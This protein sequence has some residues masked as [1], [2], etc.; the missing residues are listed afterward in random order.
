MENSGMDSR[1]MW[2]DLGEVYSYDL[3]LYDKALNAY[4]QA[5]RISI[6]RDQPWQHA[7]F[8]RRYGQ[9]LHLAGDHEKERL[10]NEEGLKLNPKYDRIIRNQAICAFSRG[11]TIEGKERIEKLRRV[12]K[13][14]GDTEATIERFV[15]RVFGDADLPD[16][17]AIHFRKAYKLDSDD[18]PVIWYLSRFLIHKDFHIEEGMEV[19]DKGLSIDSSFAEFNRLMG[20]A[21]FKK[22]EYKEALAFSKK[23]VSHLD[24]YIASYFEQVEMIE[25]AMESS[26]DNN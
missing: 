15:A 7:Q 26:R 19:L 13:E 1:M 17:A 3:Q 23:A 11:D 21:L 10:I 22:G 14:N 16:S 5:E 24:Y 18:V 6:E 8:Y 9:V 2:F 25:K 20:L 4:A 12:M